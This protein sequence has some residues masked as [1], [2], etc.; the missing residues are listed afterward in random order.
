MFGFEFGC[1]SPLLV[2]EELVR[3][4]GVAAGGAPAAWRL[5]YASDLHLTERRVRL[6]QELTVIAAEHTPDAVLLGGD[7]VDRRN[8]IPVL[9]ELVGELAA[10]APVV[11]VPGNHEHWFHGVA[12]G[13]REA[14]VA[15]GAKWLPDADEVLR[16][17]HRPELVLT[18]GAPARDGAAPRVGSRR[19]VHVGHRP[20]I[21]A[22]VGVG[23]DLA[24]AGH[25]HGGQCVWWQR[26]NLLYPGAWFTRW[27][28]LR[29][30]LDGT[31]MFVSR[32]VADT[33][34]VRFRCPREVLL[35][36]LC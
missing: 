24:L 19:C 27:N 36:T 28:G 18:A 2:R 26:G 16:H 4:E 17:P 25:L 30:D 22:A 10:V 20:D 21:A 35:V 13:V 3:P 31:P 8:G 1:R 29:F 15:G 34:P 7:L 32:G 6:T 11:A 9:R 33:L 23:S 5:L 14:V 12:H